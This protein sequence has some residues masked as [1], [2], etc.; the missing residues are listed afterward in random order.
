MKSLY[1]DAYYDEDE[2]WELYDGATY[3]QLKQKYDPED[4]LK[5]LYQKCVLRQ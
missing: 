1:S 2:F 3:R 4:R 5:D